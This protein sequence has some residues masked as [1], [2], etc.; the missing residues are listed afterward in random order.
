MNLIDYILVL[1]ILWGGFRGF[2]NGLISEGGTVLALI[3]GI[4]I[5]VRF[6]GSAGLYIS[7]YF[8]VGE[9]YRE[10]LAFTLLFVCV[11]ILSFVCTRLLSHFFKTIH[12]QWLDTLLGIVFGATKFL[13]VIAFM[14]FVLHTLIQRYSTQPIETVENSLFFNPLAHSAQGL[15]EGNI[16]LPLPEQNVLQEIK[17]N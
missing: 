14:C 17:S 8:D 9:Q 7:Q 10:V 11:V 13:I 15:L 16:V 12:L 1:P 2:K 3:L 6:S 4:W 5:S